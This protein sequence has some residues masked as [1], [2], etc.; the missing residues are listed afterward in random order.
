MVSQESALHKAEPS[1]SS[2]S[3]S[4]Q[5]LPGRNWTGHNTSSAT[6]RRRRSVWASVSVVGGPFISA[7]KS[8][9]CQRGRFNVREILAALVPPGNTLNDGRVPDR[10]MTESTQSEQ[11][12]WSV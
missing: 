12:P 1:G 7:S 4:F 8:Q 6:N 5:G 2:S 11:C 10:G 9:F 3:G